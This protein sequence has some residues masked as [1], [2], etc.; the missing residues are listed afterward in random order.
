[1]V[2]FN[3]LPVWLL[4]DRTRYDKVIMYSRNGQLREQ[5]ISIYLTETLQLSLYFRMRCSFKRS[6]DTDVDSW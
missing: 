2:E 3:L 5:L 1:M 6:I 4:P